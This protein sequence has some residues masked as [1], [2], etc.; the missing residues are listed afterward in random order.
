[1]FNFISINIMLRVVVLVFFILFSS[2]YSP[3]YSF[4]NV[5]E[6]SSSFF[7]DHFF[8]ESVSGIEFVRI[9]GGCFQIGCD[10]SM[11][12]CGDNEKPARRV[13]LNDYWIGRYEI[14]QE[15]WVKMMHNNPSSHKNGGSY[16]VENVSWDE[17]HQ[18]IDALN[19]SSK[20]KYIFRLPTEAEWE[21]ACRS[22]GKQERYS[23]GNDPG[24]YMW[25]RENSGLK[26]NPVGTKAPNGLG[27]Y[28]MSGNVMEWCQDVYHPFAYSTLP[29]NNPA[30]T[31]PSHLRHVVRGGN[32]WGRP[33]HNT[34]TKREGKWPDSKEGG[35]RLVCVPNH[36]S[37]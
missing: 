2:L 10:S 13:C 17:V 16:P 18:F 9:N 8:V 14:T 26:P 37:P 19:N 5:N 30:Y 7:D 20:N 35:F 36:A 15:Q 33:R 29:Q 25:H 1:M 23:G 27:L 4:E 6:I 31:G 21:Y 22:G 34:C 12:E 11:A 32:V 24:E 3:I 28:D